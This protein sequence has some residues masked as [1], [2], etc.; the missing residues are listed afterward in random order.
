MGPLEIGLLAGMFV[1][2]LAGVAMLA[3]AIFNFGASPGG[4]AAGDGSAAT[5]SPPAVGD[6]PSIPTTTPLPPATDTSLPPTPEPE[7]TEAPQEPSPTPGPALSVNLAINVRGGPGTTFPILGGMNMGDQAVPVGRDNS[8]SWFAIPYS[9]GSDGIGWVAAMFVTY[10]GDMNALPVLATGAPPPPAGGGGGGTSPT[11]TPGPTSTAP[12]TNTPVVLSSRGIVATHFHV[13]N[14]NAQVNDQVWFNFN[15]VNQSG[16]D[17]SYSVLAA[18][19]DVGPTA[20]SWTNEVL[21]AGLQLNWRD[22]I[23]FSQAGTYQLYLG[24][25]YGGKD[26]CLAGNA[27]WDRLSH[28]VTVTITSP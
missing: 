17:V 3:Y 2:A 1:L 13:E 4:A 18:H 20:Q 8:A 23:R 15:V 25:C 11:E 10:A 12:P 26:A 14:P 19:T 28:Y 22:H 16:S 24:I 7:P 5:G 21:G 6:L 27:P 9:A